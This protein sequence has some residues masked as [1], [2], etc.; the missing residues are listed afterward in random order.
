VFTWNNGGGGNFIDCV[1]NPGDFGD[2]GFGG[3]GGQGGS[4]G[5]GGF[6]GT[7]LDNG[8]D[9]GDGGP[10]ASGGNGG[11][12][13]PGSYGSSVQLFENGTAASVTFTTWPLPHQFTANYKKGCINSQID[14]TKQFG[15]WDLPAMGAQF[16][17]DLEVDLSSFTNNS[18]A[19]TVYFT[20]VGGKPIVTD[21]ESINNFI[22]IRDLR[23]RPE[24]YSSSQQNSSDFEFAN[25]GWHYIKLEVEDAC[26]GWSVPVYDSVFVNSAVLGNNINQV[27]ICQGDSA[28][29][30]GQWQ[31][32]EGI[33]Y[34]SLQTVYGCD[35][36]ITH[37]VFVGDCSLFGCT[38][39]EA[40]NYDST[41][42]TDDGSCVFP[43]Y[44][45]FC[46]QGSVWDEELQICVV[47]CPQDLNFDGLVNTSDMLI[48]L[49]GFGLSCF[50]IYG[51]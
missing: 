51:E 1:F 23:D 19:A 18:S 5:N 12:G 30:A 38:D 7:G 43:D 22:Y 45:I 10:G 27:N 40:Q 4:G 20:S 39:P 25:G 50:Q 34:D 44:S 49:A 6:G 36:L 16:V 46:G 26:C 37:V 24:I 17:N 15:V 48:F 3:Q 21:Q 28:F 41:A 8:G 33:Y 13:G 31:Y 29:V 2:A 11:S 47:Y 42:I 32:E 35:S 14:I 9:G